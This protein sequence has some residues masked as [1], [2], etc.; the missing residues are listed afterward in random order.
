MDVTNW[1]H[2]IILLAS[3]ILFFVFV[4][5]R[6]SVLSMN[7]L[8]LISYCKPRS[9]GRLFGHHIEEKYSNDEMCFSAWRFF[10]FRE[11]LSPEA[12]K[13]YESRN[14]AFIKLSKKNELVPRAVGDDNCTG[15]GN[16]YMPRFGFGFYMIR[17]FG[18]PV[19]I[20]VSRR[21]VL[22]NPSALTSEELAQPAYLFDLK[23]WS[24]LTALEKMHIH[25][26]EEYAKN[27]AEVVP[28][29]YYNKPETRTTDPNHW[30]EGDMLKTIRIKNLYTKNNCIDVLKGDFDN[31]M[32]NK[33]L[34]ESLGISHKRGYLLH[35]PPGNGKSTAAL[36]LALKY[37][38]PIYR[39]RLYNTTEAHHL[40]SLFSEMQRDTMKIVLFE[41]A[42]VLFTGRGLSKSGV[43][44]DDILNF[45]SGATEVDQVTYI[46]TTN[47]YR[48]LDEALLR[49]G[50]LDVHLEFT[51]PTQEIIQE[52]VHT[53][54]QGRIQ[55]EAALVKSFK[56]GEASYADVV[57]TVI[58][59]VIGNQEHRL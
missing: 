20:F 21:K 11:Y 46:F 50:R 2:W 33:T 10:K 47:K 13:F 57:N 6:M 18:H 45:M 56:E 22:S 37:R 19:L 23:F 14:Q 51:Y 36:F 48:G 3:L 41:D 9:Y 25:F 35:G 31:F 59:K 55:D 44:F 53:Y 1:V 42:D 30:Y 54:S 4:K 40:A 34:Y 39:I 28:Q 16:Q 8:L 32:L 29:E 43:G 27:S 38:I 17:L 5:L 12:V 24:N 26:A 7:H 52:I 58:D 15:V 49:R